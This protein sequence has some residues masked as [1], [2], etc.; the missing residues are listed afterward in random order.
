MRAVA[1]AATDAENFPDAVG[2]CG[3]DVILHAV[4]EGPLR[5]GGYPQ[6]AACK[7]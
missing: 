4:A 5:R 6:G 7:L 2:R 3:G 1:G